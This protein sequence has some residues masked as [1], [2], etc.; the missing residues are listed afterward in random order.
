[1]HQS[2]CLLQIESMNINIQLEAEVDGIEIPPEPTYDEGRIIVITSKKEEKANKGEADFLDT[3]KESI[4]NA[5]DKTKKFTTE[6][7][8]AVICV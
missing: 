6:T 5:Y 2:C 1:M 8:H 4:S 3:A 7:F